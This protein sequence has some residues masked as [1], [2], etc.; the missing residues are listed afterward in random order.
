[1][2][3]LKGSNAILTGA[4]RGLGVHIARRLAREGVNLVLA[5]RSAEA[6]EKVRGEVLSFGVEAVIIPTDLTDTAQVEKLAREA[7]QKLGPIDILVNNAGVEF[8]A[9]Y[10][11]HTVSEIEKSVKVNLLASMLL[12]HAVLP[13]MMKRG[14]GHIVNISSVAGK[15]GLPY[16]TAYAATKAGLIMFTHSLRV[17]LSDKPVGASVIC[18]GFVSEDGMYGRI[19]ETGTHAPLLSRPTTT[20][21]V[22]N[23]VIKG[24]THDTPEIIVNPLPARP[25]ITLREAI[26]RLSPLIH[27]MLGLNKYVRKVYENKSKKPES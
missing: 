2:K 7:G 27:N 9:P 26:P 14:R 24:I 18:P 23:A 15:I 8:T 22:V 20:D 19:E 4:S 6:L 25:L 12:T 1:M 17:E 5:A 21:K 13:G 10:E 16:Q 11:H 3:K